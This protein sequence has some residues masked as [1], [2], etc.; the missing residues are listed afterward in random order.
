VHGT[1]AQ[2][3]LQGDAPAVTPTLQVASF[4]GHYQFSGATSWSELPSVRGPPTGTSV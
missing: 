2:L 3:A 1:R 4:A